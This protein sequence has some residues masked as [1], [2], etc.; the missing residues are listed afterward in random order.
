MCPHQPL[1][2]CLAKG[3]RINEIPVS[4]GGPVQDTRKIRA[5]AMTIGRSDLMASTALA[6]QSSASFRI[7]RKKRVID[8]V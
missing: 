7:T 8:S 5:D 4:S 6:V 3:G 1:A 2:C